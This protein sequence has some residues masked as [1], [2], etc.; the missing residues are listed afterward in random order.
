MFLGSP[1][2]N[3]FP[4]KAEVVI[5]IQF[6]EDNAFDAGVTLHAV[7]GAVDIQQKEEKGEVGLHSRQMLQRCD[8]VQ[9][10]HDSPAPRRQAR[11]HGLRSHGSEVCP[12]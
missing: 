3:R 8:P 2:L 10:E 1:L 4:L 7:R 12:L 5:P 6:L 9:E 11:I